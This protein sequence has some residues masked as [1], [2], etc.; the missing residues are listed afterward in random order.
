MAAKTHKKS[1]PWGRT[2]F[3]FFSSV[4]LAVILILSLGAILAV[5]TFYEAEYGTPAAQRVIYK[6]WFVS[7][8]MFLLIL[9]LACAAMDRYPWKKH[10]VGFVVTHAGIITLIM[11]SF[12]TQQKGIDGNIALGINEATDN[13]FVSDNE[14]HIYQSIDGRPFALL[15]QTPVDFER[16]PPDKKKYEYKLAD[17]DVMNVTKFIEK[18]LRKVEVVDGDSSK[19]NYTKLLPALRFK[20]YNDRVNVSEWIGLDKQLPPFYD[21][22]PATVSFIQGPLP[23]VPVPRNQI[24]ISQPDSKSKN[25]KYAIYSSRELKPV[26][27]GDL[28]LKKEY[29]TGWMNLQFSV[30]EY[31]EHAE[32]RIAYIEADRD[33]KETTPAIQVEIKGNARWFELESPHEIHGP[34]NTYFVSYT[35]KKYELGFPLALKKFKM[36]TYGGSSLPAS[37]EST[38]DVDNKHEQ[39]I[40][41][42]EPLKYNGYTI[43]Q[44]SFETDDKGEPVLSIFSV[45][46]DPGRPIK[47][48]G[49][50]CIVG[51]IGIMFYWKPK[52]TGKNK[53]GSTA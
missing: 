8:E 16:H 9:N 31:Y 42:N 6:S 17:D 5:G 3:G 11:G 34:Q 28:D 2:L 39:V 22:G 20:L 29:P 50:L 51:G 13:F 23:G 4:K 32:P 15:V 41:M 18:G 25:L 40:S 46:Y 1:R 12:I 33:A 44:S 36:A 14:L 24:V 52:Y 10:H 37:Y 45:N 53:K 26:K 49:A 19:E 30:E 7:V 43:Y 27:V 47:Y 35:R 48:A 21:L 38:V